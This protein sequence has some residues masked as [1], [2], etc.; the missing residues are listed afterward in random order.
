MG[1]PAATVPLHTFVVPSHAAALCQVKLPEM[2]EVA[3][4]TAGMMAKS[5][6]VYV[7]A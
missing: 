7:R 5:S 4:A 1:Q 2:V 3:G 6:A